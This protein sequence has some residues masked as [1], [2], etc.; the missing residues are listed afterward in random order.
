MAHSI[1]TNRINTKDL[2]KA[3]AEQ[4]AQTPQ[5]K[6]MVKFLKVAWK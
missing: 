3:L 4:Q 2:Q 1:R 6:G 5:L